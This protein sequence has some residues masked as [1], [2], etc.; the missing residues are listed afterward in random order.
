MMCNVLRG[1]YCALFLWV[2]TTTIPPMFLVISNARS[3]PIV[4]SDGLDDC[5]SVLG[6]FSAYPVQMPMTQQY[7]PSLA[8]PVPSAEGFHLPWSGLPTVILA[9]DHRNVQQV[10]PGAS[11]PCT[12]RWRRARR[13]GDHI[14][15][16][17]TRGACTSC[18]RREPTL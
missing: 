11:F 4:D 17:S 3:T 16:S 9:G 1:M 18:T 6:R 12:S 7:P 14:S 2:P 10:C 15:R 5:H 8:K 13:G